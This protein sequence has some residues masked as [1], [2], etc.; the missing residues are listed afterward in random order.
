MNILPSLAAPQAWHG[1]ALAIAVFAS[2]QASNVPSENSVKK[3]LELSEPLKNLDIQVLACTLTDLITESEFTGESGA[4]VSGRVGIDYAIRKVIL[5]GLGDPAKATADVWR[6]AAASAVKWANKEKVKKLALSFPV[7][8]QDVSLTAK[9]IA[10]GALLA[11]HQDKRFKSKNANPQFLDQVEVLETDPELANPAIAKAQQIVDG[12]ILARELVSAPANIVTPITLAE[13]AVAIANESDYFTVKILEQADCEALNM[14]AFLGVAR[15]SDIPPK[16]IHLTYSNGTPTRKLAIVGKGLTF[17]SGGLNLK[18]GV[19][20]S[21]EL[22]KTDMGGSAAALGAAKAIAKLQP[23]DIEVHFIVASCEN[24]VNGSA[25]RPGDILTASNGK[26]I[27]VNNTD[28][29]GRLT[30]A[31]A[32]V[33]ADKLGVDAIVDLATLTGACVVALGEDIAGMWSIDDAFAEAI[34]KAAKDAGEK[35]W[36]MPLEDPYFD[37]L[38]SVVADFK[39]TG[40]RA[41]GAITGALFLKQFVEKTKV[42][43]HLDVAGPVWTERESGYNNAGGTGFAV[44]TLVNLIIN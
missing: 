30:L 26:T 33:Y 37:Q 8:N 29:E 6:K 23:T 7:Y 28:A 22:M 32:L 17:D 38:K 9:A 27:E 36:R 21:I 10:E 4:T 18:T 39:N 35:F 3:A 11:A 25:M 13:T 41:G 16:F 5:I 19:G 1:D 12:V 14:G 31:D 15:A 43:A 2:P 24:M 20:S 42:W 34:A 40:S 44:R